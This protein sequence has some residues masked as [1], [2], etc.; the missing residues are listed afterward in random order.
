M[1]GHVLWSQNIVKGSGSVASVNTYENAFG[2]RFFELLYHSLG[3]SNR[4][5]FDVR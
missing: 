3:I 2:G 1:R 5:V 4:L